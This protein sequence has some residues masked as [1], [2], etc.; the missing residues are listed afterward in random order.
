METGHLYNGRLNLLNWKGCGDLWRHMGRNADRRPPAG[1]RTIGVPGIL[2]SLNM[3]GPLGIAHDRLDDLVRGY[4]GDRW[5]IEG[6]EYEYEP[7]Y[8]LDQDPNLGTLLLVAEGYKTHVY[9]D[10]NYGW[11]EFLTNTQAVEWIRQHS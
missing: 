11:V 3:E 5:M 4:V 6:A 10:P 8:I 9:D 2:A 7:L 1:F